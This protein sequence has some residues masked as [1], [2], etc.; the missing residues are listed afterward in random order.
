MKNGLESS[1]RDSEVVC[2]LRVPLVGV[3]GGCGGSKEVVH[4]GVR[5][6]DL[7]PLSGV[8]GVAAF[9]R[10]AEIRS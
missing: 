7:C 9:T 2:V 5:Q 1:S 6:H 8:G 10:G 4:G 3:V